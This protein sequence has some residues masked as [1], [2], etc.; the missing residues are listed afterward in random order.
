MYTQSVPKSHIFL[1]KERNSDFWLLRATILF[2][3]NPS[4]YAGT[5]ARAAVH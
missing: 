4:L 2:L 3:V 5:K 1:T